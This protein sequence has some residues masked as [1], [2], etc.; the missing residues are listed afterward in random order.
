MSRRAQIRMTDEELR[1]FVGGARTII[2]CSNDPAGFPHP[3]PM[4]FGLE[5]DGAVVMTTFAKSQ[6]VKNLERDARVSLLIEDG[7]EYAKLRGVVLYGRA[8]LVRAPETVLDCLERITVRN[9]GTPGASPA[10]M[11]ETLRRTAAKRV[12]IR[13]RPERIV[14]WDHAKLGGVY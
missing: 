11:R 2:L 4:W 12:A 13:V 6:K 3:M 9:A 14:S 5:D 8:E 10:V 1:A 7:E